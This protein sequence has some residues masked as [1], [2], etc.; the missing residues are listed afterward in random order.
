L[1]I[2][3]AH[4]R[5]GYI[6]TSGLKSDVTTV[7]LYPDDQVCGQWSII[8][9]VCY[10]FWPLTFHLVKVMTGSS[11]WVITSLTQVW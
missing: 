5:N 2:F 4:A 10:I 1:H 7:L 11:S 8:G 6:S 3:T 9:Q